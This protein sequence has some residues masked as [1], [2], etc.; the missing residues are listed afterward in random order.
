LTPYEP[1]TL[2]AV[3][4]ASAHFMP[5]SPA[6]SPSRGGDPE[7]RGRRSRHR[8]LGLHGRKRELVE[9]PVQAHVADCPSTASRA[10][11]PP[12]NLMHRRPPRTGRGPA[13]ILARSLGAR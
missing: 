9:P 3:G 6:M 11:A 5:R 12:G 7:I 4:I 2:R 13:R 1:G 10:H 8:G